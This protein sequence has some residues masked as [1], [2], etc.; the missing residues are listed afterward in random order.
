MKL[1]E[2]VNTHY[3]YLFRIRHC[4]YTCVPDIFNYVYASIGHLVLEPSTDTMIGVQ[5]KPEEEASRNCTFF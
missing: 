5:P 1:P 3:Y 4:T 2:M